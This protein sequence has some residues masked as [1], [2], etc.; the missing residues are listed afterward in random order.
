VGTAYDVDA[1]AVC[2]DGDIY[3]PQLQANSLVPNSNSKRDDRI[4]GGDVPGTPA[5]P[6]SFSES[7]SS[8]GTSTISTAFDVVDADGRNTQ[9]MESQSGY[10]A[11]TFCA[12]TS[13]ESIGSVDIGVVNPPLEDGVPSSSSNIGDGAPASMTSVN[14]AAELPQLLPDFDPWFTATMFSGPGGDNLALGDESDDKWIERLFSRR[15]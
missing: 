5:L 13:N 15:P 11:D 3:P 12:S 6:K 10:F 4:E 1:D 2:V 8:V 7:P 9:G 14:A